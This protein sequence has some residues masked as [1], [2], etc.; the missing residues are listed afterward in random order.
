MP[1][2]IVKAPGLL[3]T[4]TDRPGPVAFAGFGTVNFLY[5]PRRGHTVS[6]YDV[7]ATA[8]GTLQLFWVDPNGLSHALGVATALTASGAVFVG[9]AQLN[10]P[11]AS[12][13]VAR[14]V[15]TAGAGT[16]F[17]LATDDLR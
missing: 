8:A 11:I 1:E 12:V 6:A 2:P 10:R 14:F 7:V 5:V 13:V 16:V 9:S 4:A 15:S 3:A 17:A